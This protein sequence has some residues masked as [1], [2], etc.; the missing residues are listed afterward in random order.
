MDFQPDLPIPISYVSGRYLLFSIDAVTYLRRE[1]HICG[2]LIGTLP[3]IPQQNVFLGLPLQLMPEEARLL[4]D[5]G[6]ACIV[7]EAKAHDGM[8]TLLEEDRRRYLRDLESQ[9]Q[10]ISRIQLDRKERNRE[11]TLKK[12]EEKK[13]KAKAKASAAAAQT[14]TVPEVTSTPSPKNAAIVDLFNA[15]DR[16]SSPS[17][18]S[19]STLPQSATVI[20][21]ATSYPPLLT[22]PPSSHLPAP[23]V[24]PSYPLFAHLHSKGYFLSPGLRFGCQYT[25]Y[26][27]DPL[28]FHSHFLV[29][30]YDWDQHIDLMDLVVGGRLGT[31]VKKGFLIGGAQKGID[32]V[33]SE[34]DRV[35]TVRAFSLEWAGM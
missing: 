9:G 22:P 26:P 20:T 15:E 18:A 14:P 17:T 29:V 10:H 12:L 31:G 27:G 16:P 34:A 30:S 28:R 19:T 23:A 13:A 7:D 2:V 4:V 5:K 33:D 21:P 24:P 3:Q 8:N 25:A 32:E 35:G 6:V 1:H 11:Q